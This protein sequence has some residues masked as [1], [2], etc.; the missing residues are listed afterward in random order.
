MTTGE[1]LIAVTLPQGGAELTDVR[2][3]AVWLPDGPLPAEAWVFIAGRTGMPMV[4]RAAVGAEGYVLDHYDRAALQAHLDAVGTPMLD[5]P[6]SRRRRSSATASRCSARTGHRTCCPSSS[7]G[8]ATTCGR[9]SPRSSPAR[10]RR[11]R[12]PAGLEP[13]ARR[14]LRRTLPRA[15][16]RVDARPRLEAAHPGLWH[17]PATLSEQ[18]PRRS[19]RRRGRAVEDDH[20]GALGL[21]GQPSVRSCGDRVRDLDVAALALV[22]G[23]AARPQGRS[24]SALPHGRQ[25]VDR[26][27]LAVDARRGRG[28][29][30]ALQ[31]ALLRRAPS[32]IATR[33]G[34]RCR[35]SRATCSGSARCCAKA[36]RS[37]TSRSTCRRATRSATS[38]RARPTCSSCCASASARR[39]RPRSSTPAT[40]STWSTTARSP[41]RHRFRERVGHRR[42]AIL[43]GGA[44]GRAH[45]AR[46]DAVAAAGVLG[47]RRPRHRDRSPARGDTGLRGE[48]LTLDMP[49]TPTPAASLGDARGALVPDMRLEPASPDVGQHLG[50]SAMRTS[51]SSPTRRTRRV[52]RA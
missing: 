48:P 39:C 37:T 4:K 21:L 44:A 42:A 49:L 5:A 52:R 11:D 22:R 2:G 6:R 1:R 10:T 29:R 13:H 15:A 12:G 3:D 34:S 41:G 20:A 19:H 47:R 8:A 38:S 16:R 31:L 24:R 26:P 7:A 35:T 36:G 14:A 30:L 32:T 23:D 25:P 9:I 40:A 46:R 43:H 18:P 50:A 27:R 17:P 51:I 33:G 45:D 28:R